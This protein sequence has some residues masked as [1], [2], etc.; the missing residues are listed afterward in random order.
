M[1]TCYSCFYL[2]TDAEKVRH[3][4]CLVQ[5]YF[6]GTPHSIHPRAHGNS[7]TA[8]PYVR[9]MKSVHNKLRETAGK[10]SPKQA[11]VNCLEDCG[12]VREA[13][14]GGSIPKSRSQVRYHQSKNK[15]KSS[16]QS[17]SL[18][19]VMLQCKSTN[20]NSDDA[21]V[22]SVVAAP[23]PMAVLATNRQ[24]NDMVRFLTDS[25]QYTVMGIDPTFNFGDF[26][27]TPV[28][29]RYLLLE[30]R[31]EGH[32]PI[33]LGPILVHQQ[34]KFSSYHFFAS[35]LISLC[36]SLRNIKAFGSDG[37][38]QLYQAFQMQLPEA[39]HLRC[40]RH[41]RAN[42][43]SKLTSLGLPSAIIDQYMKDIFGKTTS[44]VHEA[45]LVDMANEEE[46]QNRVEMLHES[47]DQREMSNCLQ[48]KPVFFSIGS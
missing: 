13:H 43:V 3:P 8:K 12:G 27:V 6:D 25:Q 33:I 46:F 39:I 21:F 30:H 28:A 32:S 38:T 17:D 47:W 26:N 11:L 37:E 34:K 36:P 23:E 22:R 40:F 44:G 19:S 35:T 45:G 9:S 31:K 15:E 29:Y 16:S 48:R 1:L 10:A 24:L 18:F 2:L 14:S 41:F 4:L 5:Y 7:K 20:P 42:L